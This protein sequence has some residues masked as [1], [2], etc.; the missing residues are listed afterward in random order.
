[1]KDGRKS[2]ARNYW[3]KP[4]DE[5]MKDQ[6]KYQVMMIM[7]S[8]KLHLAQSKTLNHLERAKFLDWQIL[9]VN[10]RLRELQRYPWKS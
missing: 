3:R 7:N 10:Y 4:S 8:R 6:L 9:V 2:T 5:K 1:M